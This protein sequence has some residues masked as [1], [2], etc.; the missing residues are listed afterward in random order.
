MLRWTVFLWLLAV[1]AF[2]VAAIVD[3]IAKLGWGY[4]TKDIWGGLL[5]LVLGCAFWGFAT[6]ANH[7]VLAISRRLHGPEPAEPI[8]G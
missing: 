5:M 2:T 3:V 6:L 4:E 8:E 7:V 1:A